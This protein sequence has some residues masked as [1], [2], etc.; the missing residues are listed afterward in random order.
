MMQKI[1]D[2]TEAFGCFKSTL[3]LESNDFITCIDP[4]HSGGVLNAGYTYTI[5]KVLNDTS[6]TLKEDPNSTHWLICRFGPQELNKNILNENQDKCICTIDQLFKGGCNCG[7][8]AR[9]KS[10]EKLN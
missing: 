5:Q 10:K 4:D 2:I 3:N 6:I 9:Y 8:F 1:Y 7:H